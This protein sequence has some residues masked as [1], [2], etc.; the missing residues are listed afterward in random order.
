MWFIGVEVE[1]GSS[2]PP[3]KKNPG[4]P[5]E[6][7]VK[8][9]FDGAWLTGQVVY[10]VAKINFTYHIF[11]DWDFYY[12]GS[13]HLQCTPSFLENVSGQEP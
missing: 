8:Y 5:P 2:A 1:Q 4:S 3:P 7:V 12:F 6:M 9:R 11:F 10:K 13:K